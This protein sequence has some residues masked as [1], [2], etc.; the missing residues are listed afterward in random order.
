MDI[1][2]RPLREE[3]L[4]AADHVFRL[5]FGTHLGLP[6][7]LSFVGDADLVATRWR[8]RP[9]AAVGVFAD[10]RLIGS[11]FAT[12][13]GDFGFF[14]PVTVHPDFWGHGVAQRLLVPTMAQFDAWGTRQAALFTFA[15]SPK[16]HALYGKFGFTKQALTPVMAKAVEPQAASG[17]WASLSS[18]QQDAR[19]ASL[20]ACRTLTDAV[21]PGLDLRREIQAVADQGLGDTVL[22][23]DGSDLAGF[24][25]CHVGGGSEAGSG[26]AY[27]KFGAARPGQHAA[28]DFERLLSA[29]EAFAHAQGAEQLIAG[30]N[31]ARRDAHRLM[32]ERGF[33]VTFEGVAMQRPDEPG[34]N[35]PD[36]FVV[37]DWR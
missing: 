4:P 24:A 13:W 20:A 18:L 2:I 22:V 27:L 37:D 11:S 32:S 30:V 25:V 14:G 23:Y 15:D 19:A 33:A 31:A 29:C 10:G 8:A 5:A 12:D 35:R 34:H 3:D 26:A 1:S 36:C 9:E 7:P 17:Q 16:H 6:D 28:R 21:S